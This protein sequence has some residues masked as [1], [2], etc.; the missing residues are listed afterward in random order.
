MKQI[1]SL[2][3]KSRIVNLYTLNMIE[4]NTQVVHRLRDNINLPTH[5]G[6]SESFWDKREPT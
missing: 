2:I 4:K 6:T 3:V 1:W 5:T